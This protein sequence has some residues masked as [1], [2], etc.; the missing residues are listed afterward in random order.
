MRKSKLYISLIVIVVALL[1]AVPVFAGMS[2][3][4]LT[5]INIQNLSSTTDAQL[6]VEL[7]GQ[8]GTS[9]YDISPASPVK[10]GSLV[11]YYM[12]SM[13]NV[14]G[15]TYSMIVS[16]NVPAGAIVRTDW[17]ATGGAGI[18]TSEEPSTDLTIP[19]ILRNYATQTSEFTVQNTDTAADATDVRI[20]LYRKGESTPVKDLPNQTITKGTS[21][22]FKLTDAVWGI[23]DN[24]VGSIR[25]TSTKQLVA[26]SF[27]DLGGSAGVT[28]FN[29][30]P[31]SSASETLYC[32]LIRANYFGD[33]GI[34]IV[35][36]NADAVQ[37]TINFRK[38]VGPA[39]TAGQSYSQTL[40]VPGN[41]SEVAFQGV[42]GNSRQA[43]TSLP[44]GTQNGP[45]PTH[46]GAAY[47]ATIQAPAGKP[48]LAVVN[49]TWFNANWS[50]K[51]QSTYNC[52][53]ASKAGAKFGLPL[54]RKFHL[55]GPRLTTGII[56]QNVSN[57]QVTVSLE[58]YDPN[59]SR[60][61]N[62]EPAAFTIDALGSASLW[63]GSL[64]NVNNWYGAA[65]LKVT[66]GNVV[67]VVSDEGYGSTAVDS[68][69]Y[70]ALLM[71]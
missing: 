39:G 62:A 34:S 65:I 60:V 4:A 2:G 63:N 44:A 53:S 20:L 17:S 40:T 27:I 59:G 57:A 29:A 56:V 67:V 16:S 42:G 51:S 26:Q 45:V 49:D 36:P 9:K 71:P 69:N 35:N 66:G 58:L 3:T 13:S 10:P 70:N 50:A 37:V 54:V 8:N 31:T 7:W 55:S 64:Q 28:A 18:Y 25:I 46:T 43:P 68:A 32:P 15:G 12:P 47:S 61:T 19:L 22:T 38:A 48:I 24:F 1:T 5:G 6:T 23:T 21:K 41:S 14:A 33:T 52:V 30:V 11:N